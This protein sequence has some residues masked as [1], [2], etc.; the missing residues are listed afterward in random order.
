MTDDYGTITVVIPE[1]VDPYPVEVVPLIPAEE[2]EEAEVVSVQSGSTYDSFRSADYYYADP[3]P[4][5]MIVMRT[6]DQDL[7]MIEQSLGMDTD[8]SPAMVMETAD[9]VAPMTHSN[10]YH[11]LR[12]GRKIS[13]MQQCIQ[14]PP[15]STWSTRMAS[16]FHPNAPCHRRYQHLTRMTL[17]DVFPSLNKDFTKDT[18]MVVDTSSLSSS[19]VSEDGTHELEGDSSTIMSQNESLTTV[20]DVPPP[21]STTSPWAIPSSSS[22]GTTRIDLRAQMEHEERERKREEMRLAKKER[23][24]HKYRSPPIRTHHRP[25]SSHTPTPRNV[26]T[27]KHRG[28]GVV[29]RKRTMSAS[30]QSQASQASQASQP[31]PRGRRSLLLGTNLRP[32][33]S[34]IQTGRRVSTGSTACS[35]PSQQQ[36]QQV[37]GCSDEDMTSVSSSSQSQR[38]RD[39]NRDR[40]GG[41]GRRQPHTAENTKRL[42]KFGMRCRFID[43]S[44][45][46]CH[47]IDDWEPGVC[48]QSNHRANNNNRNNASVQTCKYR[49]SYESKEECLIRFTQ[50]TNSFYNDNQQIYLKTFHLRTITNK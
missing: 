15:S 2:E 30:S 50:I 13:R 24:E 36:Q 40:G 22:L 46:R 21:P 20:G 17:A 26:D 25:S 43:R 5:D 16:S 34:P 1:V 41:H 19:S 44:C 47:S 35:S 12:H 11:G 6:T 23:D 8:R 49:H 32:P 31:S 4:W 18:T 45:D 3:S 33:S 48:T 9:S 38:S 37:H 14:T 42:C 27:S 39:R 7:S 29:E 10:K 28:G